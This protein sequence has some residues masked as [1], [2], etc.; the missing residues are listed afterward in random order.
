MGFMGLEGACS[1]LFRWGEVE[2]KYYRTKISSLKPLNGI[3][4]NLTGSKI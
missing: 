1:F 4:R 2:G 3:Q